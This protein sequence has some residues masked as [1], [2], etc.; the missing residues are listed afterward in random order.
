MIFLE[1]GKYRE[2]G[3]LMLPDA[4]G[5]MRD[6]GRSR[7]E[8]KGRVCRYEVNL[9]LVFTGEHDDHQTNNNDYESEDHYEMSGTYGCYLII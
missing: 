7:R 3:C 6:T 9:F 8:R 1:E 5:Q 4:G 2:R